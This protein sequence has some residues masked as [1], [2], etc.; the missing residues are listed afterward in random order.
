MNVWYYGK[1]PALRRLPFTVVP[2][3]DLPIR[4]PEDVLAR[5]RGGS[6]AVSTTLL[7]G[8]KLTEAQ[9]QAAAYLRTRQPVARTTTFL[10]YTFI[11][12]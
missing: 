4:G 7:Y 1:D 2:L 9:W 8:V 10:I 11:R 5:V 12:E 3:H 6:L